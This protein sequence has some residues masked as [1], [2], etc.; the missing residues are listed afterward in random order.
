MG[1]EPV[2]APRRGLFRFACPVA[3]N[4]P[5]QT[6]LVAADLSEFMQGVV[7]TAAAIAAG[8]GGALHLLHVIQPPAGFRDVPHSADEVR[9]QIESD[10]AACLHRLAA[11]AARVG[12][13]GVRVASTTVVHGEAAEQIVQRGRELNADLIVVGANTKGVLARTVLGSVSADVVK[14]ASRAVLIAP[15]HGESDARGGNEQ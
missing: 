10:E 2:G 7:D 1:E 4:A 5:M 15:A 6:I 12:Q 13:A 11:E 9:A 14:H 3:Q 8:S